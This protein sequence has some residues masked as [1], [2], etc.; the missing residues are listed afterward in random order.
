MTFNEIVNT[1]CSDLNLTST[2]ART[3]IGN[4]VNTYHRRVTT[5]LG[6]VVTRRTT[7]QANASIGSSLITF[8]PA[9][10]L[11]NV[12]DR[13]V[14]PYRV[15]DEV[16]V[17][18]L[19]ARQ[20]YINSFARYYAIVG[21]TSDTVTIEVDTIAQTAFTLYADVHQN[22]TTLTGTQTPIFSESFH[23]ILL[24]GPMADEY[25]KM[26][27]K[28]EA[29]DCRN[30]YNQ[31]LSELRFWFAKSSYLDIVQGATRPLNPNTGVPG[32]GGG[33]GSSSIS[34]ADSYTQTGLVTF[35]RTGQPPGSRAPFAVAVGSEVVANLEVADSGVI[36][37]D[38]T[39]GNASSAKHGFV[40]KTPGDGTKFLNGGATPS[41]AQV[42][43]SD[44]ALTDITTNNVSTSAHGFAP[45]IPNTTTTFLRGD[46]TYVAP[47]DKFISNTDTGAQNN[48]NP[49]IDGHSF[50]RWAGA[51]DATVTGMTGGVAGRRVYVTNSGTKVIYFVHQ[52]GS[53]S[54]GNKYRNFATSG[55]TPVAPGGWALFEHDGT[56]WRLINH[57]QGAA[58]DYSS[59]STVT[60]WAASPTVHISYRLRGS[61]VYVT[62]EITGTS[63]A[64][65]VSFTVPYTV[66]LTSATDVS[67]ALG[68][69]E[70]NTAFAVSPG[71]FALPAGSTVNCYKDN[72]RPAWTNAGTKAVRGTFA[73]QPN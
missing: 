17:E 44:L 14:N 59:T 15:L 60:G 62:F 26:G 5:A 64:T 37:S 32:A 25:R 63:N 4:R 30:D 55:N 23:D 47:A 61:A 18:Q 33:S 70:D 9:E 36:F 49:G 2:E 12:V 48:W 24:H 54:A 10:H 1:I 8:Q 50:I 38:I 58:I 7:E 41:F 66:A 51:S 20:P 65:G 6:M 29:Q 69:T 57:D 43:D 71:I 72:T 13:S 35:N 45:K 68:F 67:G 11:I 34:G 39:T 42:K 46:G 16:T 52:S 22:A 21:Y 53:S 40:P 73:Y 3:R 28:A 31:R 56:D 19:R 27:K